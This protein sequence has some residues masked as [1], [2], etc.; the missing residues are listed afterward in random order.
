[1]PE[2]RDKISGWRL[3]NSYSYRPI[4]IEI[5]KRRIAKEREIWTTRHK[6]PVKPTA[7]KLSLMP[8]AE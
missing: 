1:M 6:D 4:L 2:I 8:S 3:M 5:N 7:R